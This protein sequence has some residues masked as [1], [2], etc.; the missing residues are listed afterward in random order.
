MLEVIA[1]GSSGQSWKVIGPKVRTVALM[2]CECIA[3][4]RKFNDRASY[5]AAAG[6]AAID[7]R[8]QWFR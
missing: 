4:F 8:L 6:N 2:S 5:A 3:K 1:L 7:T